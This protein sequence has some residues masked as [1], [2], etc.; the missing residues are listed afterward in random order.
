MN[1]RYQPGQ[2]FP[3][4]AA[5]VRRFGASRI[6]VGHALRELQQRGFVDRIAGSGTYVRGVA[7]RREGLLFGLIIPDLGETEIFEPICHA[8][9]ASPDAAGHALLWPHADPRLADKEAQAL[10]GCVQCIERKVSGVFF[11][12]LEL[13]ERSPEANR[14]IMKRLRE[15]AMPVVFLDR[16]PEEGPAQERFDLAALDNQRAGYIATHHLLQLGARRIG[17]VAYRHQA[18]TVSAR[19]MGYREALADDGQVIY[20]APD[21][22]LD[23]PPTAQHCD[24]FVCANDRIAGHWMH[25]LLG[26]GI[27]IPDDV[28]LVGI[29]DVSYA[30]LLPVPLTTVHQP[31]REIGEAALRLML[32]RL[33]R[34]KMAARNVLL[35]GSLV[36]RR[37][38]GTKL[39]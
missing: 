19:I 23:V 26:R 27:R 2:K 38:C 21:R 36:I 12:P 1:G 22:P 29:D 6:T 13:T 4:E 39:I 3:S 5:L 9:A 7:Q 17:F 20:A 30:G 28:R 33:D 10:Q 35:D 8:I 24:A 18:S 37:S 32:E 11:A 25:A 14:R 16:R 34:P 31:C 15:A